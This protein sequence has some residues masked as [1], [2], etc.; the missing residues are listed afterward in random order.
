MRPLEYL[1]D[2]AE[3]EEWTAEQAAY[4]SCGF[5][6]AE[7]GYVSKHGDVD[8][9]MSRNVDLFKK[10]ADSLPPRDWVIW[11]RSYGINFLPRLANMVELHVGE[12]LWPEDGKQVIPS[13]PIPAPAEVVDYETLATAD[14]L[15]HVFGKC[16]GVD[17]GWFTK[18]KAW[19]KAG[20]VVGGTP[21]KNGTKAFYSVQQFI[22]C[23]LDK[24]RKFGGKVTAKQ[25]WGIFRHGSL[26]H[27]YYRL[28]HL[29]PTRDE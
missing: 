19:T 4:F 20:R 22:D 24:K 16:A 14:Q 6:P 18:D 29:D 7:C 15:I 25:V 28:E 11:A 1:G 10:V 26:S 12:T 3:M 27:I 8:G 21:G 9:V 5:E 17:R 23:L 2:V 13:H